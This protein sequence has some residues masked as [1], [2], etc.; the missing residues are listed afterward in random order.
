[1]P[2]LAG[3]V[4]ERRG[5]VAPGAERVDG[6]LEDAVGRPVLPPLGRVSSPGLSCAIAI[7]QMVDTDRVIPEALAGKRI[8]VTGATGFLGTALVE[9]LLRSV[10]GC[11]LVLLVRPGRRSTVA[12]R[13]QREIFR[14]DAFDRLRA[15]LAAR[16][17]FD[18][19]WS[20][21]GS[22]VVAG[23]VGTDGLGLDDDGRAR[24]R[25]VRHRRSTRPPP[26]L[27]LAARRR[28]RGQ[29]ARARRR[30]AQTLQRPRRDAPP[31]R[32]VDLLRRRQPPG[33]GARGAGRTT[34][35]SSST[36]TGAPRS[37][38]PAARR[39]T[40]RPRAA[41][42]RRSPGSASEARRE[43][44][45][46]GTPLLAG[47]D[48]AAPPGLGQGPLVEAGRARAASLGWPDAYAY[49]KA[50]GE[51]ALLRAARRRPGVDRAPVDHRVGAGRAPARL[52]PR[53]PHGRAGDHHLRPRPAEGV[54]RRP[55][56]HRRRHPRRPRRRRHHRRRRRRPAT[57][58]SPT[59]AQVAS[60]SANPLRYRRLVDLVRELVHRAPALRQR[61]PAHR[62]A[63]VVLPRAGP[64]PGP[65]RAGEDGAGP[66][67]DACS[68]PC[69]CG[70]SR[71]RGRPARGAARRGRAGP[72]L[73]RALRRLRRVRGD[74]RRRP[75]ARP[76][77]RASTT[78]TRRRF[79]FDPA[80]HRLDRPTSTRSTCRRSS[81]TPGCGRRPG[82]APARTATDR[83]R[84][85]VL[86]PERHLAAFDLENTLIASNVVASYAWLATRRL[87]RED[88]VRFVART[89]AEAPVAAGARPPGPQRLPAPL[90][91]A[92]RGRAGRP[93]RR[94]RRRDVQPPAPHQVVPGRHPPGARAPARSAT[95]RCSSPAPSTSSSSRCGRCSTT[96]CAPARRAGPTAP[97]A[98]S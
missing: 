60:G 94:G 30:I 19:P 15:E 52:D 33:R 43:L 64:G 49:T 56:G 40:P 84:R 75:A 39:P 87:P 93:A 86:A 14:N 37:T 50:L 54:P 13:A 88:R 36:S 55:R 29:P 66:G 83:L 65:A 28:G 4:V 62:R 20:T 7:Y 6:G 26:S 85:Q 73:R 69:R 18:E 22:Q 2:R 90:L 72:R 71:R 9:R 57:R 70:A 91:P 96:S 76:L 80:G 41:R 92:L 67:R 98:A 59:I 35:R 53:L 5:L 61:G 79:C 23:D 16:T 51:R 97:T 74:L 48:R 63:R 24:A 68:R 38:P 8:V 42:P 81:S 11:E 1:M 10:P 34:A 44:G 47:Q 27:R 17:A 31:R 3:E 32:R 89:L 77:R 25:L 21:A 82:G 78:P 12:Q 45:A 58:T 95:A 46:A